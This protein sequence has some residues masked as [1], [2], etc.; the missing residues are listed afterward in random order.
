MCLVFNV[1]IAIIVTLAISFMVT[2]YN[3]AGENIRMSGMNAIKESLGW[4]FVV[5]LFISIGVAYFASSS[6]NNKVKICEISKRCKQL[7]I[8]LSGLI[9]SASY[10]VVML[11]MYIIVSIIT[12]SLIWGIGKFSLDAVLGSLYFIMLHSLLHISLALL[13]YI[14]TLALKSFG[15]AMVCYILLIFFVADFLC[16]AINHFT[17]NFE[18]NT[19]WIITNMMILNSHTPSPTDVLHGILVSSCFLIAAI[20]LGA[21]RFR[22]HELE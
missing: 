19:Y 17:N 5:A 16:S 4:S 1:I 22:K 20:F 7:K 13:T 6:C 11:L 8:Y 10:A 12:V 21:S 2:T 14:A 9:I 15:E 3:D 18:S